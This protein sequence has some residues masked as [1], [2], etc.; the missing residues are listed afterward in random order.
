MGTTSRKENKD[1]AK[2]LEND[3]RKISLGYE[4]APTTPAKHR[5]RPFLKVVDEY[6]QWGK[7]FGRK[8]GKPWTP[9]YAKRKE[10]HLKQ[11]AETLSIET[12]ADLDGILPRVEAVLGQLVES[13]SA[14]STVAYLA[15]SLSSCCEWCVGHGYLR[16]NPLAN[17]PTIDVTPPDGTAGSDSRGNCPPVRCGPRLASAGLCGGALHRAETV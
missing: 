16:E 6:V 8:D 7:A 13:G 9:D 3:A 2:D 1:M 15:T 11:W 17:L 5:K 10:G 14:G 12:L 4:P